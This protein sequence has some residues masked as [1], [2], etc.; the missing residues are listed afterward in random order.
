M[1]V[2]KGFKSFSVRYLFLFPLTS[3]VFLFVI[4]TV[5]NCFDFFPS[6]FN[7][8]LTELWDLPSLVSGWHQVDI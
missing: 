8:D 1:H 2:Q 4:I 6:L 3:N 7:E 5:I